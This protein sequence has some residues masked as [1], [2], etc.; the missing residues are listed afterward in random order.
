[1]VSMCRS[2]CSITALKQLQPGAP[3]ATWPGASTVEVPCG[4][5]E[6]KFGVRPGSVA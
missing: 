3:Q 1:M 6:Q 2:G 5:P 4:H